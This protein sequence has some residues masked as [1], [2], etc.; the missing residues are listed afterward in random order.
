MRLIVS[1]EETWE[2]RCLVIEQGRLRRKRE[3][4]MQST[5][6]AEMSTSPGCTNRAEGLNP[7]NVAHRIEATIAR[8]PRCT[9]AS[10]TGTTESC[11]HPHL[12]S[13]QPSVHLAFRYLSSHEPRCPYAQL[14]PTGPAALPQSMTVCAHDPS[15]TTM[16]SSYK[17]RCLGRPD[18]HRSPVV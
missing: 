15:S 18:I 14:S 3:K 9:M 13:P 8:G 6:D 10:C 11:T 12:R 16:C 5:G 7:G 1:S 17:H 4:E 2:E